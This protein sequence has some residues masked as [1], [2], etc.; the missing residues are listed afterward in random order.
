MGKAKEKNTL[1][2]PQ[3]GVSENVHACK[4]RK[5]GHITSSVFLFCFVRGSGVYKR[6]GVTESLL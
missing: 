1:C 3:A 4:R 6:I 5:R 2:T